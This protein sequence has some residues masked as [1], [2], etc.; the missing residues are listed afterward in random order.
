MPLNIYKFHENKYSEKHAFL[1]STTVVS[2]YFLHFSPMLTEFGR[3]NDY[4]Y[5][6]SDKDFHENWSCGSH[7]LFRIIKVFVNQIAIIYQFGRN[8][9]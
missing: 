3:R 5:F 4:K 8:L 2:G 7:I 6:L 1:K 9:V